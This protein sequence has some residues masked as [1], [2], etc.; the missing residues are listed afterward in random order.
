MQAYAKETLDISTNVLY[1]MVGIV[2][3]FQIL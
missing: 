2:G 1:L 3:R